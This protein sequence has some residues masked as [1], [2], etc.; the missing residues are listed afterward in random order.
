MKRLQKTKEKREG[1]KTYALKDYQKGFS[2]QSSLKGG[3]DSTLDGGLGHCM[4][5]FFFFSCLLKCFMVSSSHSVCL[6]VGHAGA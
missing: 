1:E 5:F 2:L 6:S 4:L 3:P